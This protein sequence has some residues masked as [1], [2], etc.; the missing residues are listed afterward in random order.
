[1]SA[2]DYYCPL[3]GNKPF[4]SFVS[5]RILAQRI[6]K[7]CDSTISQFFL[8]DDCAQT[9]PP[10]VLQNLCDY[11]GHPLRDC[12]QIWHKEQIVSLL[13]HLRDAINYYDE[14]GDIWENRT[15]EELICQSHE[16][17]EAGKYL[18]E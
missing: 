6:C 9:E 11:S 16:L 8:H 18:A 12:K 1:M 3:C 14:S 17:V 4:A 15:L 13:L 7:D 2:E 5:F 10:K